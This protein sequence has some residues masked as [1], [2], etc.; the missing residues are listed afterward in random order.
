MVSKGEMFQSGSGTKSAGNAIA[1]GRLVNCR[2]M[3][4]EDE[5]K[6]FVQYHP[7]LYCH[8][9]ENVKAI[10]PFP[11][12]GMQGWTILTSEQI[13]QIQFN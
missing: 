4:P 7:D 10:K 9:Y 5:D 2:P 6:C 1:I 3:N 8:I 12:K 11:W 13:R